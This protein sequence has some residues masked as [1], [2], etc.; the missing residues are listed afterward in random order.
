MLFMTLILNVMSKFVWDMMS[1]N[2][3]VTSDETYTINYDDFYLFPNP[4]STVR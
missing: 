1:S 2:G 4:N 3:Q